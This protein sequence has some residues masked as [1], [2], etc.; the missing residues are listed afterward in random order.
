MSAYM[1]LT[2]LVKSNTRD[3]TSLSVTSTPASFQK[4]GA[5]NQSKG[6]LTVN[7]APSFSMDTIYVVSFELMNPVQGQNPPT[8]SISIQGFD[9]SSGLRAVIIPFL[10]VIPAPDFSAPLAIGYF[11]VAYVEQQTSSATASNFIYAEFATSI[12]LPAS[13]SIVLTNISGSMMEMG[14]VRG[15][16]LFGQSG[17]QVVLESTA[18]NK[19]DAYVGLSI[20]IKGHFRNITQY[21]GVTKTATLASSLPVSIAVNQDYYYLATSAAQI[22]YVYCDGISGCD[23]GLTKAYLNMVMNS[24]RNC[25][26]ILSD[27]VHAGI[28]PFYTSFGHAD[29]CIEKIQILVYGEKLPNRSICYSCFDC[30]NK[31]TSFGN[32]IHRPADV[33][34]IGQWGEVVPAIA[35]VQIGTEITPHRVDTGSG[36]KAPM[37][38]CGFLPR[39][40]GYPFNIT[41]LFQSTPSSNVSN[42]FNLTFSF[43]CTIENS[44]ALTLSGLSN[45]PQSDGPL[46]IQ[47]SLC[48]LS[49]ASQICYDNSNLLF[50]SEQNGTAGYA[51][52]KRSVDSVIFYLLQSIPPTQLVSIIFSLINPR[53]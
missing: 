14:L 21:S 4:T 33:P 30:F 39:F 51:V 15:L 48:Y 2:N 40:A 28:R 26:F 42:T 29:R 17:L 8:V 25:K 43:Y 7:L 10:P 6:E 16:N 34:T 41:R 27:S 3:N 32:K 12:G 22:I 52:W 1:I 35:T 37:L 23:Y 19:D 49:N 46:A 20:N 53:Y 5:W 45:I 24:I 50:S 36:Y 13:T 44:S 11:T 47:S 31:D 9:S 18:S 38:I